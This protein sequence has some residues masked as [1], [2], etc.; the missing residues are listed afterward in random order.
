MCACKSGKLFSAADVV[1]IDSDIEHDDASTGN[2]TRESEHPKEREE[3]R[4]NSGEIKREVGG[5]GGQESNR[6]LY[7][8]SALDIASEKRCSAFT[9]VILYSAQNK[10]GQHNS[11]LPD[12]DSQRGNSRGAFDLPATCNRQETRAE[13][14]ASASP[15][16]CDHVQS[17]VSASAHKEKRLKD[18]EDTDT[19]AQLRTGSQDEGKRAARRARSVPSL[20]TQNGLLSTQTY[21]VTTTRH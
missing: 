2:A 20:K 8:I 9:P 14:L 1:I 16:A 12:R 13:G 15:A 18:E 5:N 11:L 17:V 3:G 10:G 7:K 19:C 4:V 6:K 21:T